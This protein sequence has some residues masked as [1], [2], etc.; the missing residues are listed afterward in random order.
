MTTGG[1]VPHGGTDRSP[2]GVPGQGCVLWSP[3]NGKA[4]ADPA[5]RSGC[6][7]ALGAVAELGV[8]PGLEVGGGALA[9]AAVGDDSALRRYS[10]L[11][12]QS[13]TQLLRQPV[14]CAWSVGGS[15][16]RLADSSPG[17]Y[18]CHMPRQ[19]APM[20]AN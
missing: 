15:R 11:L 4:V 19:S 13:V 5:P 20:I 2:S 18:S 14:I 10:Q 3:G 7:A 9:D 8:Q 12:S 1:G 16:S 6:Q 17:V